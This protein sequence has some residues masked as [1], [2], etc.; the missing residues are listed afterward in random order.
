MEDTLRRKQA[1]GT[2]AMSLPRLKP[3]ST[4]CVGLRPTP[5]ITTISR[6]FS[7]TAFTSRRSAS[8]KAQGSVNGPKNGPGKRLGAKKTGGEHDPIPH[9]LSAVFRKYNTKVS[10]WRKDSFD[11]DQDTQDNM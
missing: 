9:L 7:P 11:S 5:S 10:P 3:A 6:V 2:M 8:H 4:A 1:R